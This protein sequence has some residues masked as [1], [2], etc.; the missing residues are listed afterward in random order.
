[1]RLKLVRW[2]IGTGHS[3]PSMPTNNFTA[4]IVLNERFTNSIFDKTMK[5]LEL[6]AWSYRRPK[7]I[8]S[9]NRYAKKNDANLV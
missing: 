4:S 2:R 5:E 3:K 8:G 7:P 1:M 6:F 9:V